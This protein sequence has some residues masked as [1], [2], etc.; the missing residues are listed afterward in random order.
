MAFF[1][2][3]NLVDLRREADQ[4]SICVEHFLYAAEM[5]PE[6]DWKTKGFYDN[7][8]EKCNGRLKAIHFLMESIRRGHSVSEESQNEE[9]IK[10][11]EGED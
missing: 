9:Q 11:E 7:C 3:S 5:V 2:K 1:T 8:I 4:L 10:G 6:G